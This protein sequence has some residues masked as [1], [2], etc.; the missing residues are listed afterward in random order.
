M[1]ININYAPLPPL[2]QIPQPPEEDEVIDLTHLVPIY[3]FPQET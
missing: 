2:P 1:A 3:D